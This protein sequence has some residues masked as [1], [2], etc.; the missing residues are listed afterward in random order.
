M[1]K[2]A[3]LVLAVAVVC[4]LAT[5]GF[6]GDND[7]VQYSGN[8]VTG[9]VKTVGEAAEGTT[10]TAVSPIQAFWNFLTGKG[11]GEKVVTDPVNESG[12]TI[13]RAA[14]NTGKTLRGKRW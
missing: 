10:K 5:S 13:N 1:K 8:V 2:M 12:R 6:A 9:S 11:S 4:V 3:L 14:E 7:P